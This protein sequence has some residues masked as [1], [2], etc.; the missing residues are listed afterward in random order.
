MRPG[1]LRNQ[2]FGARLENAKHRD[3]DCF[4]GSCRDQDLRGRVV[5]DPLIGQQFRADRFEELRDAAVAGVFCLTVGQRLT[6]GGLASQTAA[7]RSRA[8]RYRNE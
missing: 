2:H 6:L 8:G 7:F 4:A 1:R 5:A 3:R